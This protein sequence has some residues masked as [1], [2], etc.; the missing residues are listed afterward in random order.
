[1]FVHSSPV[2]FLAPLA[3]ANRD[4]SHRTGSNCWCGP[5]TELHWPPVPASH[6]TKSRAA[7][8]KIQRDMG[9]RSKNRNPKTPALLLRREII[10][11]LNHPQW[12]QR[13]ASSSTR[14][15]FGHLIVFTFGPPCNKTRRS[16]F[17]PSSNAIQQDAPNRFE[18]SVC[19]RRGRGD[20]S[21]KTRTLTGRSSTNRWQKISGRKYL[22]ENTVLPR[23]DLLDDA[24]PVPNTG[25]APAAGG[26]AG[27]RTGHGGYLL[28]LQ[29]GKAFRRSATRE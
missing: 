6:I 3:T 12:E 26:A 9:K 5:G 19:P 20:F 7:S 29:L 24:S 15:Q 10:A 23:P 27:S 28:N 25:P 14:S 22:A 1:M 8:R 21:R 18:L 17:I 4:G 13:S 2:W 11:G 16:D